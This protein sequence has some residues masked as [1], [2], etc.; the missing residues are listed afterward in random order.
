MDSD[1]MH[2][3]ADLSMEILHQILALENRLSQT[4]FPAPAD[5]LALVELKSDA[6]MF[7]DEICRLSGRNILTETSRKDFAGLILPRFLTA[8]VKVEYLLIWDFSRMV[9]VV[10]AVSPAMSMAAGGST[11]G[12]PPIA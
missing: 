6:L 2:Q 8:S 11:G 4:G 9:A 1:E 12:S 3:A 5:H 10:P 7:R